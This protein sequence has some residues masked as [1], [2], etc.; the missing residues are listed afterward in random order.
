MDFVFHLRIHALKSNSQINN[1]FH[2]LLNL[3][4]FQTHLRKIHC[5]MKGTTRLTFVFDLN[6]RSLKLQ[7]KQPYG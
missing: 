6:C 4:P 7:H 1:P 3:T 5:F 2:Q